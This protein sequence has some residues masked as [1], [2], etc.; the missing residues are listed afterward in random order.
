[1]RKSNY[2]V[3]PTGSGQTKTK[4]GAI[5]FGEDA[6][7]AIRFATLDL[8]KDGVLQGLRDSTQRL[9]RQ[10][11]DL[12]TAIQKA[13]DFEAV[14]IRLKTFKD[15]V[16]AA[17]DGVDKEFTRLI[18]LFKEAGASA[19]EFA[20]LEELYGLER[21]EAIESA[22]DAMTGALRSLIDDLEVGD[23]GLSLRARLANAQAI[24]NPLASSIRAGNTVDYDA[25][26]D[27]AR[28]VLDISREIYGSQKQYFDTF[29]EVLGLSKSAL[30]EQEGIISIADGASTPFSSVDTVP[31]VDAVNEQTQAIYGQFVT[32]NQYLQQILA[33]IQAGGT[34]PLASTGTGGN[35]F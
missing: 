33:A 3:D 28:T 6:E 9:L 29:N 22:T 19:Q 20:D 16:G 11:E 12:D 5:D 1:M 13:L 18:K 23:N 4:R 25:F 32:N 10:S 17:I 27:A 8:I 34:L 15:P 26:S 2:R 14:F 35:N 7:A 31:V 30:A 21:A 24:Y